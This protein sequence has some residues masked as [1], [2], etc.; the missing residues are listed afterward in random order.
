MSHDET[1][2]SESN[3]M[4]MPTAS[5][6]LNDDQARRL[7]SAREAFLHGDEAPG[8]VRPEIRRSWYR[9]MMAG[10][11]PNGPLN[12]Q[13]G[14][15]VNPDS[16]LLRA[17][18][19][20]VDA[21]VRDLADAHV[22]IQVVDRNGQIVGQ[23]ATDIPSQSRMEQLCA[24]GSVI[25]EGH[26][27]TTVLATVLEERRPMSVWGP[28]HFHEH[29]SNVAGAGAPI[30]HP[31]SGVLQGAVAV[32]CDLS[33]PIGLLSTLVN[34]AAKEIGAALVSGYAR[35]DRELL[36]VFLRLERRGPR[37]PV[38]AVNA[39]LCVT[40]AEAAATASALPSH[41]ELWSAV[42]RAAETQR[43]T[44]LLTPTIAGVRLSLRLV[45]SGDE[46]IGGLVQASR[47]SNLDE[48]GAASSDGSGSTQP[49]PHAG[50]FTQLRNEITTQLR[51]SPSLLIHGP[52]GSGK[53]TLAAASANSLGID[54]LTGRALD[55]LDARGG[56]DLGSAD[57]FLITHLEEVAPEREVELARLFACLQ[58]TARTLT[59]TFRTEAGADEVPAWLTRYFETTQRVPGLAELSA[60]MDAVIAEILAVPT[61][62]LDLAIAPEAIRSLKERPF[63]GNMGQLE[64]LLHKARA[65]AGAVPIMPHHL[66]RPAHARATSR[67][68]TPLERIER[69]AIAAVLATHAGN[70]AA[71][72]AQLEMSRSTF[73]RR[74]AQLGIV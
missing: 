73:Y 44:R 12:L 61:T 34:Q 70:K 62:D 65:V 60:E 42:L 68:L 28:E 52:I 21:L 53:S 29:L 23:W 49:V 58:Q 8:W 45:H 36:D 41:G 13:A 56:V 43:D 47:I 59:A 38:F 25:D 26:V 1:P 27:G 66:P 54:L 39:R 57:C 3:R 50:P 5:E 19:P 4:T 74:L 71:A 9:S 16:A 67:Q 37:R 33:I 2:T 55:L 17:A 31:G 11:S 20:V 64:R 10:V 63:P 24:I 40:N 72:A 7:R 18:S 69:D 46:L 15:G 22:W 48:L 30:V 35:A 32:G 14:T 6:E 51:T